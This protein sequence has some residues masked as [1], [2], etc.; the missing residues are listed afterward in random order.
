MNPWKR[1][2]FSKT[3]PHFQLR[4]GPNLWNSQHSQTV[5][6]CAIFKIYGLLKIQ[7]ARVPTTAR[8]LPSSAPYWEP[9]RECETW[10]GI[11]K[12]ILLMEEILHQLL[13]SWSGFWYIPDGR[14]DFFHQQFHA[15]FKGTT[16]WYVHPPQVR[17]LSRDFGTTIL[18][19]WVGV[20]S[21]Y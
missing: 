4:C 21:Q 2:V 18:T 17:S 7:A 11:T 16:Q 14:Q 5:Y 12:V 15:K 19:S 6:F 3:N 13:D 8:R 20:P 9:R 1:K 10:Q